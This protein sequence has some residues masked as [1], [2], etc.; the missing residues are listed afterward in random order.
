MA[1]A[2]RKTAMAEKSMNVL[3]AVER[4][5]ALAQACDTLIGSLSLTEGS[6]PSQSVLVTSA[7]PEEGKTTVAVCL[8]LRMAA[9]GKQT[10]VVDADL[11]R[12][13]VHSL[14]RIDNS[15]GIMDVVAGDLAAVKAIREVDAS[16][17]TN[18]RSSTLSVLTSGRP[19]RDATAVL[20]KP[21]FMQV[22]RDLGT[23]YDAVVIDCPPVL[24]VSDSLWLVRH[25]D[26]VVLVLNTGRTTERDTRRAKQ[27]I[28]DAGGRVLGAVLNLFDEKLHGPQFHPYHSY[29]EVEGER[30]ATSHDRQPRGR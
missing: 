30:P 8:A 13:M 19:P 16:G 5:V 3:A 25:V 2:G 23:G 17:G 7:R 11:R 15:A 21:S 20:Q 26:G 14:L 18:G 9:M 1:A 22:L 4:D 24:S 12:P 27:R 6:R 10:L 28:E 29:Y